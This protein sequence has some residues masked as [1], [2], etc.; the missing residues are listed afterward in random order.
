VFN[1][2]KRVL[3]KGDRFRLFLLKV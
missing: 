3:V 2:L 1:G